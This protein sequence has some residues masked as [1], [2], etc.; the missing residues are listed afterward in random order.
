M[1]EPI[2]CRKNSKLPTYG[3]SFF[4]KIYFIIVTNCN[5]GG[6][7]T[8]DK[9]KFMV[10]SEHIYA[11]IKLVNFPLIKY[12]N[13]INLS[14]ISYFSNFKKSFIKF[15]FNLTSSL[16]SSKEQ[17]WLTKNSLLTEFFLK[18][19]NAFTQSKTLLGALYL[20]SNFVKKN[21]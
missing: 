14:Q 15:D 13:L 19:S 4:N 11:N 16:N 18:N 2:D 17:R 21:L 20:N 3:L 10:N 8:S 12:S 6:N 1:P 9:L 7:N 5:I